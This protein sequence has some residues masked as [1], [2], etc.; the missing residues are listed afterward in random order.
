[1]ATAI[2]E[3]PHKVRTTL[4]TRV[5]HLSVRWRVNK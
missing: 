4:R 5:E 1:L 2:D 3:Q